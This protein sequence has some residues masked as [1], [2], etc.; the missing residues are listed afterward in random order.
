MAF[1]RINFA[2]LCRV[3]WVLLVLWNFVIPAPLV[4]GNAE[5]LL[6]GLNRLGSPEREKTL[7]EG[8]K[9]EGVI[10]VYSSE[11]IVL[12]QK[13]QDA[14]TKIHPYIKIK[15][16]RAGGDR[17]GTRV[18]TESRAGKLEADL[19]GLAFDVVD[20]IKDTG[21]LARYASPERKFY[22]DAFKDNEGY[23]T[24]T[25]LIHAVIG[26]NTDLVSPRGAPKDYLDLLNPVWRGTLTIDTEPARTL[27]GWLKLWGEGKTRNYLEGLVKNDVA[28]NRGH[29]LQAQLVCAG[30]YKAAVELYLY[31]AA[32]MKRIGCPIGIAYPNPTT[33]ASAQSWAIPVSAPHPYAAT[34]Y[35]DFLLGPAGADIVAEQGRIP[36]RRGVKARYEELVHLTSGRV[37]VQVISSADAQ[38]LRESANKLIEEMLFR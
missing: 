22:P 38:R 27:M 12:L 16:W 21:I 7:V 9:K 31:R 5:V 15:H 14:F 30:Q 34:L 1:E 35:L 17:V 25:N 10:G 11:N 36:A 3:I 32:Q 28:L 4:A 33:V 6:N 2:K 29:T 23:F 26:Y 18:L 19:I 13:Y 8:A 20:E 37:P 24:P